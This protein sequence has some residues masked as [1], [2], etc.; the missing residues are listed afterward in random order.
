MEVGIFGGSF[1]PPHVAHLIVADLVRDQFGL[2]SIWWMPSAQPP[3]KAPEGLAAAR[4]RLA[5]TRLAVEDNPAFCVSDAEIRRGG[6]SYT[7]DTIRALQ[8]AHPE[9]AFALVIGSD[10]LHSFDQWHRPD[11]IAERV[12]LIVYRRPGAGSSSAAAAERF[13]H[14]VHYADAPLLEISGT[15][16]R[17]RRRRGRSVRYLTPPAV[18]AYMEEHGLYEGTKDG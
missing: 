1:N 5:M 13:A 9:T 3:H 4:H 11:E 2:G 7:V 8:E 17:A 6:T 18:A 12:P 10:S 15:A 14:R 16:I